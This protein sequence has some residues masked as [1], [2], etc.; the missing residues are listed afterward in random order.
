MPTRQ[1]TQQSAQLEAKILDA[2]DELRREHSACTMRQL[3]NSLRLAESFCRNTLHSMKQR[4]LVAWTPMP[5]SLRTIRASAAAPVV[6]DADGAVPAPTLDKADD[7]TV[8]MV[9]PDACG[10]TTPVSREILEAMVDAHNADIVRL[11]ESRAATEQV[12]AKLVEA[13]TEALEYKG[14]L[15]NGQLGAL[16]RKKREPTEKEKA[17]RAEFAR[18]GAERLA[19]RGKS[20]PAGDVAS[21]QGEAETAEAAPGDKAFDVV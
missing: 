20:A 9:W 12:T 19:A 6:V 18:R 21:P 14:L 15:T 2:I 11:A 17:A 1:P 5:G 16:G 4:G 8:T 10:V 3:A 7:G 13:R